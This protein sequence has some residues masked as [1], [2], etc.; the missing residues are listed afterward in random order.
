M[1]KFT[2]LFLCVLITACATSGTSMPVLSEKR[3]SGMKMQQVA[4]Y[5]KTENEKLLENIAYNYGGQYR[6]KLAPS[7]DNMNAE[8]DA[9]VRAAPPRNVFDAKAQN[10]ITKYQAKVKAVTKEAKKGI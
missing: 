8:M 9:L 1:K 5:Y 6:E 3:M 2:A 7:L 4:D 10:I